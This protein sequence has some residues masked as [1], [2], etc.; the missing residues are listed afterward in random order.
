MLLGQVVVN[1]VNNHKTYKVFGFESH[2]YYMSYFSGV[3]A[4]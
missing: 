1:K 3:P 2:N 4:L